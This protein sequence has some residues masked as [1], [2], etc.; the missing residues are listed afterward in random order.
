LPD[1]FR[2]LP[3][4]V[5]AAPAAAGPPAAA[6]AAVPAAMLGAA[7]GQVQ[8][9][10]GFGSGWQAG[11]PMAADRAAVG[12]GRE[13]DAAGKASR[14]QAAP[15]SAWSPLVIAAVAVAAAA[16]VMA[17]IIGTALALAVLTAL[18]AVATTSRRMTRRR[19]A[20][21]PRPSDPVV[22]AAFYPVALVRSLFGLV[23]TAP[24]ALLGLCIAAAITIVAVPVHPLPQ[25]LA[26]GA[27]A[28]VALV[29]L[30]PGSAG[31]RMVLANAFT[32]ITRRP[33]TRI[34]AYVGVTAIAAWAGLHAW[35]QSQAPAYWPVASLHAQ[36][37]HLPGIRSTLTDVR[38]SLL[39]F[40]RHIGL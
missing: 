25:A 20:D 40:A 27:G 8:A 36:L 1:D 19:S 15:V 6:V 5:G 23:L 18:R 3:P 21:G 26:F 9:G 24:V 33:G 30:G 38:Q 10:S 7:P 31:S 14:S 35:S 37:A 2:D 12:R 29:G 16:S 22:A 17:P 39:G 4:A 11:D 32:A 13:P 34:I 28:L